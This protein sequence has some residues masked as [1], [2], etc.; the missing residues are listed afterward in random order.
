MSLYVVLVE[1]ASESQVVGAYLSV[2]LAKAA[3]TTYVESVSEE[4]IYKKKQVKKDSEDTRHVLY[5]QDT[6]D[7]PIR[8]SMSQVSFELPASKGKKQKDPNAPK[9]GMSA[10]MIF[11][12]ENRSKIKESNPEATFADIGKMVGE[13]WRGL[14]EKQKLSYTNKSEADKVR[15]QNAFVKYNEATGVESIIEAA[16]EAVEAVVEAAED[17][18]KVKK[19]TKKTKV[20]A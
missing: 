18:K 19:T 17:L 13:S 14:T 12:Q 9:K 10:F 7:S 3:A 5:L 16:V 11:S 8:V 6:K 1:N 2:K 20:E 4:T 15:Y